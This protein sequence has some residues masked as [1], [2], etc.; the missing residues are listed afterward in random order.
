MGPRAVLIEELGADPA[1]WAAGLRRLA[2]PGVGDVVPAAETVLVSC[3]DAA[4]M[5]RVRERL[6]DVHALDA[7]GRVTVPSIEVPVRYDGE[8]LATV[9]DAVGL[10]VDEVFPCFAGSMP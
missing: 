9:A 6:A 7:G 4:A 5:A 8:D 2:M 3:H 1:E 10:P